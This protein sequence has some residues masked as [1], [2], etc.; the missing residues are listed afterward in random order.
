MIKDR[1]G[2][3]P[4]AIIA[5]TILLLASVAGAVVAGQTRT[6][7]TIVETEHGIDAVDAAL[8]NIRTYT[9]QELGIII[10]DISKDASLGTL[11]ERAEEFTERANRWID[12]RF[13][14]VSNGTSAELVGRNIELTA[15]S[16]TLGESSGLPEGFVPAYLHGTGTVT[17]RVSSS[18]G[19]S[20]R[21]IEISTD[22]SYALPLAAERGSLFERM[23]SE[24]AISLSQI[25]S[26]ELTSVAQYRVLNGYGS[27]SQ[28]GSKGTDSIITRQDVKN[29]YEN[30]LSICGTICF[31]NN[32]G[33]IHD[34]I[35]AADVLAGDTVTIDRASF[36]G[37][38]LVSVID[39]IAIKW[40]DYLRG[41][42]LLVSADKVIG[43]FRN[44][45]DSLISFVTGD[46]KHG[47]EDYIIEVME[48]NGR[49]PS[50]YRYPGTGLTT[51]SAGGYTVTVENPRVDVLSEDWIT[52]FR[53]YYNN[54]QNYIE[55]FI[56]QILNTAAQKLYADGSLKPMTLHLDPY[57]D[58]AFIDAVT[59]ALRGLTESC[60]SAVE[61]AIADT[62]LNADFADPFYAAIAEEVQSRAS[63]IPDSDTLRSSITS[64]L[65]AAAEDGE[66]GLDDVLNSPSIAAAIHQYEVKVY[67]DLEVYDDLKH[68]PGGQPGIV[69]DV[70]AAIIE[71]GLK[72]IGITSCVR[73]RT[74]V[75]LDEI[76]A[77]SGLNPHTGT[78][79]LPDSGSFAL[80]DGY[81]NST[82]ETLSFSVTNS[83]L[84][85]EPVVLT[86][87]CSHVTG[88]REERSAAYTTTFLVHISDRISY[89]LESSNTF[90]TNMGCRTTSSYEDAFDND[91]ELRISVA[92]GWALMGVSYEPTCDIID[93]MALILIMELAALMEPLRDFLKIMEEIMD[94]INEALYDISRFVTEALI[95][96]YEAVMEPLA[97]LIDWF[98]QKLDAIIGDAVL[99]AYFSLDLS[100]QSI[101]FEYLG[102]TFTLTFNVLSLTSSTKTLFTA[103]LKGPICGLDV[104]VSLTAKLKGTMKTENVF[105][106]G[107]AKITGEDWK[108]NAKID[109]L[110][111]GSKHL[112]TLSG[113]VR[114]TDIT[115]V[116]PQLVD[117]SESGFKLSDI[118]GIGDMI[119]NIPVPEL[120]VNVGFDAGVSLKYSSPVL[121]GLIINEYET[122]PPGDDK[123]SEWVEL[124]NNTDKEIDLTGY[125]LAASS[126]SRNKKMT[127]SGT[128]SPGEFLIIEPTFTLVN[129]SGKMT[130]NGEGLILKDRDGVQLDK[131]GTHKDT[132]DDDFTWQRTYDGSNEWE[133]KKSTMGRSNGGYMM[134]GILSPTDVKDIAF[135]SL[136]EAFDEVG[137]ITD[138][139]SAQNIIRQTVQKTIDEVIEK[140]SDALVEASVYVRADVSDMSS[141]LSGGVTISLRT[142]SDLLEDVLKYIAGKIEELALS[143]KNPY[144]IDSVSMFTDNIDLEITFDARVGFPEFLAKKVDDLPQMDLGVTFRTNISALTKVFGTDTGTPMVECGVRVM[145]CPGVVIPSKLS[146]KAGMTHDL[147]LF[148]LTLE[149]P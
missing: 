31:R 37:Q 69:L 56:V 57:D 91:I 114:D 54:S 48:K 142:D 46:N 78:E 11:D 83:P 82:T 149:W 126:D 61:D 13:P 65:M 79:A 20:E 62:V 6:A 115:L 53:S 116:L 59:D 144:K 129:S 71:Y 108:V 109:P 90:S 147:W 107:A 68:V 123:G 80:T 131:T 72:T 113:E 119:G 139:E 127:L 39:D 35:D 117:Y 95:D 106:T 112:L 101:S 86:A 143:I 135:D 55:D 8:E 140:V 130:K 75:L 94:G 14:M 99:S 97:A 2:S 132:S 77:N 36:Y 50:E 103:E 19:Y 47:A 133:F 60:E 141:S 5:V 70:L 40:F 58:T 42:D 28:Y 102:F 128:I 25:M 100:K 74:D 9:N 38:A 44:A 136:T 43:S 92:S 17:V 85:D 51:V 96:L 15:E 10:L 24:G 145:D 18:F 73:D 134:T 122:N 138:I 84:I 26:Y 27:L 22:G 23:S 87:E 67:S 7:E 81:G 66:T 12:D 63:E 64:A 3:M 32:E 118:P 29:A 105:V 52:N 148:R 93:D 30:A 104:T 21:D 45:L 110:M 146:P 33:E 111:K 76:L 49:S 1:K 98:E 41:K 4:F 120:G 34:R 121:E 89:R 88:F 124:L 137:S 125:T 16:M